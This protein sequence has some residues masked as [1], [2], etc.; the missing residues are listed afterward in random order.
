[1]SMSCDG[2][3][4][5]LCV[6]PSLIAG[7]GS[8]LFLVTDKKSVGGIDWKITEYKGKIVATNALLT[9][10]QSSYAVT[11]SSDG[12]SIDGEGQEDAPYPDTS[13][14]HLA[15]QNFALSAH[16]HNAY[17]ADCDDKVYIQSLHRFP[18]H[19]VTELYVFYGHEYWVLPPAGNIEGE[20]VR[21]MKLPTAAKEMYV[22]QYYD[23]LIALDMESPIR[24]PQPV[25][26]FMKNYDNVKVARKA[27]QMKRAKK[28]A[29][30]AA[31]RLK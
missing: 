14:A 16:E 29:V 12:A 28:L 15:N 20:P 24:I 21:W 6:A 17:L 8:G 18:P 26:M 19:T 22:K 31:N 10:G 3:P 13:F 1:M 30:M 4:Y 23:D 5:K 9:M 27:K 7:A 11:R 25:L 2:E